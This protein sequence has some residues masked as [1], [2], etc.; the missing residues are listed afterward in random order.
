MP[1]VL[2]DGVRY[3]CH[4]GVETD[5]IFNC[6]IDLQH[7]ALFPML[8][9]DEGR[10][11]LLQYAKAQADIAAHHG[12]GAMLETATWMANSDR[13]A[14][15]GY[16]MADLDRVNRA[17]VTLL[18]AV[19]DGARTLVVVSGQVGPRG[20]GY[21]RS[22]SMDVESAHRYH[23][24]Q[25]TSLAAAGADVVSAFTMVSVAE[26]AGIARAAR[27]AGVPVVVAFTVETDGALPDGT[28]LAEAIAECDRMSDG[29]PAHYLLNCAHPDHFAATL[30]LAVATGRFKGVVVN[31]SRLSHA[32]LDAAEAL[33]DGD[34]GE[35]GAQL[36]GL[37]RLYPRLQ[38]FGG[39][40]G[41]DARHLTRIARAL[42]DG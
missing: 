2:Q 1:P 23:A 7:F 17:A 16:G 29:Y 39:C 41:T 33:D 18:R 20:D 37:A 24:P 32:E 27:E 6:G 34:P 38:V 5:L 12:L 8:D 28:G 13:A 40:C 4:T 10:A 19:R 15:L 31:A 3:L 30:D 35:L 14:P 9:T 22:G 25:V 21:S 42:S 36:A 11:L 26:S